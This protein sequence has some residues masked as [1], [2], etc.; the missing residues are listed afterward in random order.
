MTTVF[1]FQR[2]NY[3]VESTTVGLFYEKYLKFMATPTERKTNY[4]KTISWIISSIMS[5]VG[6]ILTNKIIMEPPFNFVYVF[7]LTSIH[8]FVT[9]LTM[10]LMA[11]M[12][13]FTRSRLPWMPSMLMAV[14]CSLSV[15]LTN[16][17][18]KFNSVGFYQLCKLLGIPYLVFIQAILY[19]THT[20]CAIKL[21]LFIILLGMALATITDVQLNEI[22]IIV[23]LTGVIITT[24][25]Q[26][27]QG[28]NQHDYKLNALQINYAQSLPTFFVCTVLALLVEFGGFHQNTSILSHKWT[29]TEIKW[30]ALSAI[31]AAF[32]NLTCY[33]LIGNTSAITFQVT[34]HIKTALILISGYFLTRGKVQISTSNVIGVLICLCGSIVYGA[35]RHVEQVDGNARRLFPTTEL[36][37]LYR[38]LW[39]QQRS[40][41][42]PDQSSTKS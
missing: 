9:A 24:Q 18:L 35:I 13:L 10:E 4:V 8:F 11:L 33:G 39:I 34:G 32:A 2:F 36:I 14:A 6:L 27:W 31:L 42:E 22:G 41:E 37:K 28:K 7:T 1:L 3:S 26:I 25:F 30:I 12:G 15:A 29:I 21:S 23:G 16:L 20:S 5:S 19:K 17:S 40:D 38:W